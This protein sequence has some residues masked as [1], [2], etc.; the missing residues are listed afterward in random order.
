MENSNATLA[1]N[2][3]RLRDA[4]GLS[5]AAVAER[6]GLSRVGYRKVE[7]GVSSPRSSTLQDIA[8][9][10]GVSLASLVRPV[11]RLTLVRFR[12]RKRL[13]SREQ[14][15]ALVAD[16]LSSFAQLEELLGEQRPFRLDRFVK[17]GRAASSSPASVARAARKALDLD[18]IEPIRDICGLL[19]SAGVKVRSINIASD[20]FFGLSVGRDDGG[21]AVVVNTW[22][23]IAV[24]RW[25]FTAAH[26]LG[27]IL[28]HLGAY[29]AADSG[30]RLDEEKEA[31]AFAAHFLL[32]E[33]AF[34]REW[35]ASAGLG[36][37]DRVLKLKRMFRVSYRTV[38]YRLSEH[39]A[40]G[41]QVWARFQAQYAKRFGRTLQRA[42][43]PEG[44]GADAFRAST[45]RAA[46]EP[47]GLSPSDFA[48][49]RL[50]LLVRR[51]IEQDH[52]TLARGAE[53]LGIG[54][55]EM[56]TLASSWVE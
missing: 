29:D 27:H 5:Q 45:D 16:W 13:N 21:P 28:L 1:A 52:I 36:F 8:R 40:Y 6:A 17:G 25:I 55:G 44:L 19:E 10:L 12:S 51:A 32:P 23:R 31:D 30:E 49:D 4:G 26:E 56:R 9:A 24:E 34:T 47:Y 35:A 37:V 46:E 7:A 14:I 43:E 33:G 42:D 54:L 22:E 48:E 53:V 11:P 15:L 41:S 18:E 38:L 3:R 50:S 2:L 20:S 39:P